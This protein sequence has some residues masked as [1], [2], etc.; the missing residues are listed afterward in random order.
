MTSLFSR[1][2][3]MDIPNLAIYLILG[4]IIIFVLIPFFQKGSSEQYST[5]KEISKDI[6]AFF[7]KLTGKQEETRKTQ[8]DGEFL[9]QYT[10]FVKSFQACFSSSK[11]DCRCSLSLPVFSDDKYSFV[12]ERDQ[13]L[14]YYLI[15]YRT[16]EGSQHLLQKR[17]VL[18]SDAVLKKKTLCYIT[19][20]NN[21]FIPNDPLRPDSYPRTSPQPTTYGTYPV[22]SFLLIQSN[23]KTTLNLLFT[24]KEG[25]NPVVATFNYFLDFYKPTADEL[26]FINQKFPNPYREKPLCD[27]A[28][29]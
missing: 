7:D 25:T 13:T 26:C 6:K 2:A 17:I 4:L 23:Q 10:S 15:P 18:A 8:E 21:F 9:K 19:P 16:E 12:L 5:L 3:T 20:T 24:S 11:S 27:A 28:T 29:P 1:K 22:E 14:G